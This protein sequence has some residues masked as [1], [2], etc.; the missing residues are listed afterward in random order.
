[1]MR[2]FVVRFKTAEEPPPP[3]TSTRTSIGYHYSLLDLRSH[4]PT[5]PYQTHPLYLQPP[6]NIFQAV[7][8][9][10]HTPLI[11]APALHSLR[12]SQTHLPRRYPLFEHRH[13]PSQ[14]PPPP[15]APQTFILA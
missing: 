9:L 6:P 15:P 14:P 4:I 11:H 7:P 13:T 2:V 5:P 3:P 8:L 10:P 12:L 1:M